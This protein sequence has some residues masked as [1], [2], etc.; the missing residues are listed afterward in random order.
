MID[1]PDSARRVVDAANAAGIDI[2]VVEMPDST[3]T[4]EDAAT[5][6]GCGVAQI[7][8]S[9]IFLGVETGKPYLMLVS[10]VNRVDETGVASLLGETLKRPNGREVRA[11][12]GYAIGG[13]PPIGH[14]VA[15]PA[16][17]DEKLLEFDVVWA[18]AGT[19]HCVFSVDPSALR[20][21]ANARA[22]AF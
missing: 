9:L 1:L 20:N 5:A 8:K 21:A 15:M 17:I 2:D 19:P 12:T 6:C 14:P 22:Y 4:A 16:V 3:R 10:G 18:A 13:I 7:V 11:L